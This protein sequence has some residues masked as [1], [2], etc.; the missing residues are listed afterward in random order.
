[1]SDGRALD[2]IAEI[3]SRFE[4]KIMDLEKRVDELE[5]EKDEL[6]DRVDELEDE[7]DK[8]RERA[9]SL[10]RENELA[11]NGMKWNKDRLKELQTRELEKG[12]QLKTENLPLP[13]ELEVSTEHAEKVTRSD[14]TEVLKLPGRDDPVDGTEHEV[15]VAMDDL[16]PIQRLARLPED[17]L[18]DELAN[19]KN[20]RRA[21]WLWDEREDLMTKG[22]SGVHRYIDAGDLAMY[23]KTRFEIDPSSETTKRVMK[24]F[25]EYAN[26]RAYIKKQRKPEGYEERRLIIPADAEIPGERSTL[27]D[28]EPGAANAVVSD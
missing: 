22:S 2:A 9:D 10:E 24:Q 4:D 8:L 26:N 7:N 21:V 19:K 20:V 12:A 28:E 16:L 14:G 18:D 13:E 17:M 27:T 5:D 11:V 3:E 15:A 6:R 1:M 23:L 25:V